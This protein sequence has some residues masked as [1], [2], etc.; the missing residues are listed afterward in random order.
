MVLKFLNSSTQRK[1][2]ADAVNRKNRHWVDLTIKNKKITGKVTREIAKSTNDDYSKI[3]FTSF[4]RSFSK[5]KRNYMS[6]DKNSK[7][8]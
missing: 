2:E 5:L 4:E 8:K 1:K 6:D 3:N 7:N